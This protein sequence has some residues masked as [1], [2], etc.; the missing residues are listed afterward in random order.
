MFALNNA[1]TTDRFE[2][3]EL[4]CP[5]TTEVDITV[6]NAAVMVQYAFRVDGYTSAAPQW[7]PLEGVF[8]PPG[9]HVRGRRVERVRF[10]S[11]VTGVPSQV[12]VEAV[13]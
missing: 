4:E 6:A 9:F 10:K 7:A 11:A 8:L 5:G 1:T 2:D 13:S 12:T 3:T